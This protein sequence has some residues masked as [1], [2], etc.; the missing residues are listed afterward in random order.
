V[1]FDI[2]KNIIWTNYTRV[3]A[4]LIKPEKVWG[5]CWHEKKKLFVIK[6]HQ[7]ASKYKK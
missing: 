4:Y 3:I 7:I 5:N 2:G 1:V 6:N